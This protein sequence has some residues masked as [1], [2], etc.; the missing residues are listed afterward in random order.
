MVAG[1]VDAIVAGAGVIGIAIA[2]AL[3]LSGK[4]VYVIE[5]AANIG[6]G[7][8]SRSSEVMH[9]GLYYPPGS[10]KARLC[11]AGQKLLYDYCAERAIPHRRI[12]K[13]IVATQPDQAATLDHIMSNA[14]AS[15]VNSLRRICADEARSLEPELHCAGAII[16]PDTGII[17]SH[18][19]MLALQ[20]DAEARGAHFVCNN[21]IEGGRLSG[22]G[23]SLDIRDKSNGDVTSLDTACFINAAGL[24]SIELAHSIDGFPFAAIPKVHLAKGSYFSIAGRSPFSRLIYPVPVK[25]GLG[26]HLTLDLA[27]QA[28]F[29]PDV[30]WIEDVDYRVDPRRADAFY[31]EIRRYWP[32]LADGSLAPAYAGIRPKIVGPEEESADFRIDGPAEHGVRGMINLFGIESPG[33]T[34]SLAIADFVAMKCAKE[35]R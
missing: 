21:A 29:G 17:D 19:L 24:G 30:E 23:I 13:L 20:G 15:G 7:I 18:A 10:L 1:R 3:S 4:E 32:H 31:A 11:V 5:S 35:M 9:A 2:R 22:N 12:G 27:N 34:S 25:G 14:L 6:T 8:S 16:S 26:V 28:R 33:L